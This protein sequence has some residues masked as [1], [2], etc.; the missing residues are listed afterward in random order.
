M[1]Y[2]MVS[3]AVWNLKPEWWGSPLVQEKCQ[4]EKACGSKNNN[5]IIIIIKSSYII[6]HDAP[7]MSTQCKCSS[8][9]K[10]PKRSGGTWWVC[11]KP[12]QIGSTDHS[13]KQLSQCP[14]SIN[15]CS[16]CDKLLNC[17][18]K[19]NWPISTFLVHTSLVSYKIW[20]APK[21][22][23]WIAVGPVFCSRRVK[24]QWMKVCMYFDVC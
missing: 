16:C 18:L 6:Y 5:I 10:F 21:E 24:E 7:K 23:Q 14:F 9:H 19:L 2:S 1:T 15:E 11:A 20:S 12:V 13:G 22:S 17:K 8:I 4:E 3:T